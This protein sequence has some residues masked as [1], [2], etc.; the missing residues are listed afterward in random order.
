MLI[1]L[2]VVIR[3]FPIVGA[4]VFMTVAVLAT[5]SVAPVL[6]LFGFNVFPIDIVSAA[7]GGVCV[8]RLLERHRAAR[9]LWV[10]LGLLAL[11]ALRGVGSFG[12]QG[13]VN[14]SR[15][16][17]YVFVAILFTQVCLG[18]QAWPKLQR[19]WMVTAGFL[20]VAALV[21][22]ARYGLNTYSGSGQRALDAS[23]ALIVAQAGLLAIAL[24]G[25]RQRAFAL[26]C[27]VV[28]L[29]SQQRTVWA[30]TL[31]AALVLAVGHRSIDGRRVSR[32]V[33]RG[34]VASFAAV[35]LLLVLGPT[36]LQQSVSTA[37]S[38]VST[39]SSSSTFGWRLQGWIDLLRQYQTKSIVDQAVGQPAGTG[40]VRTVGR[41]V[42]TA[43]PHNM[44]VTVLLS[45]GAL[46]LG[47]FV[48]LLATGL[49]RSQRGGI[50]LRAL[51]AGL[52][53]FGIG[54]QFAP[55]QGLV[56][57]AALALTVPA[58]RAAKELQFA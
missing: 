2:M 23:Q 51:V 12:T 21:Y 28:V 6:A 55:E 29:A 20:V 37:T 45:L 15:G 49:R 50:A 5:F 47:A 8:L 1:E 4:W 25:R 17:L 44:Y 32:T 22:F 11:A 38:T 7:L 54:Y 56:V 52:V 41:G 57:G 58:R 43:S 10:V 36:Q 33:R 24:P 16:L 13:A 39:D 30:A 31:M 9:S 19:L 3:K 27:F 34:L 40:F 26:L 42:V 53:V 46:G 48:V 35:V 18:A 14:A